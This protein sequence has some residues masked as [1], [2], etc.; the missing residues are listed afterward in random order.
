[1]VLVASA[2]RVRL[3]MADLQVKNERI[4]TVTD[5]PIQADQVLSPG[6]LRC[7]DG[8]ETDNP[9][10]SSHDPSS[11]RAAAH[12]AAVHCTARTLLAAIPI[13]LLALGAPPRAPW[14]GPVNAQSVSVLAGNATDDATSSNNQVKLVRDR[15]GQLIAA[16]VQ[17]VGGT[18][19]VVLAA[20][21]DEGRHWTLLA[22]ASSGP[23]PS[24]LAALAL[25]GGGR[26]HVAWTRYDDGVGKIYYRVWQGRWAAPQERISPS[27][28]YAGFP[29][30]AVDGV[31]NPHVVWYGIRPAVQPGAT[32]HESIYEIFYTGFDGR[33]WT[34]PLLIS[35]GLPDAINPAMTSDRTGRLHAAWYQFDGRVY[36]VRYA[37]RDGAWSEPETVLATRYD[38]FSPDLAVDANG[39]A[40]LVWEHHDGLSSS[41]QFARRSGGAWSDP[42]DL[43]D[44]ASPSRHPSVSVG[45]SGTVYVAWETG[46]GE[47]YLRRFRTGW[48][49]AMRLT[50]NGGDSFPS[51]LASDRGASIIWTHT[52]Q[53]G[54]S[55]RYLL[56]GSAAGA[57]PGS[58]V[59]RFG[60]PVIVAAALLFLLLARGRRVLAKTG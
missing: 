21:R 28:G 59:D 13:A 36:Q 35:T 54:S 52:A 15:A 14:L 48:E 33:A 27:P 7:P 6:I 2:E 39:R 17:N 5:C 20:T 9:R 56:L 45:P 57:T 11:Y 50:A 18:P 60:L 31:G 37:A 26:L 55:V 1:M 32:R 38:A 16:Y 10:S 8:E 25:D 22:Q 29:A 3:P 42:V 19:Q 44:P 40:V 30:L 41:I 23:I 51:L 24:R 53:G 49:P 4:C 34:P 43:S 58:L 12:P 47:I 46:T